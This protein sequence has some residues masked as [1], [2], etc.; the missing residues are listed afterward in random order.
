MND[1]RLR[2]YLD[3]HIALM[4]AEVELIGR[5]L[6]SNQ[7]TPLGEFLQQL[8]NEVKSQ[9]SIA[10]DMIHRIGGKESIES[11]AKQSVAWFA[12]KVGRFKLNDS[13]L[14]YSALSRLVELEALSAAAQE[15]IA[16]WDNFDAVASDD[17]RLDG[18]TFSFFREQSEQHLDELN[19][20]R[21]FA[22][23]EAFVSEA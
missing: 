11:K 2:I 18:I 19:S 5:C 22:A 14:S 4:V 20:R 17:P 12:E 1:K 8:E 7:Q 9:K 10:R 13:L 23:A 15:R 6:R 16:V 21:R 3:D